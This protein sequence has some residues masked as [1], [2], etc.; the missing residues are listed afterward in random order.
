MTRLCDPCVMDDQQRRI[1]V[2]CSAVS[3]EDQS[4]RQIEFRNL[5]DKTTVLCWGVS[6]NSLVRSLASLFH[7]TRAGGYVCIKRLA[8]LIAE[9]G[10]FDLLKQLVRTMS[11]RTSNFAD[12]EAL[13]NLSPS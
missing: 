9:V 8:S 7:V 1:A 10:S 2:L 11:V 6:G 12:V 3:G 4:T 13:E 5:L